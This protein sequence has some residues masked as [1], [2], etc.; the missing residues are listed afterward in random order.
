MAPLGVPKPDRAPIFVVVCSSCDTQSGLDT[1]S[2]TALWGSCPGSAPA[3][4]ASRPLWP[5]AAA[6]A[7]PPAQHW[8]PGVSVSP[9]EAG[10]GLAPGDSHVGDSCIKTAPP[11]C[12]LARAGHLPVHCLVSSDLSTLGLA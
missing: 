11:S 9:Q 8:L 3:H 6:F 12:E 7:L 10:P 5:R 1:P 4:M 2:F